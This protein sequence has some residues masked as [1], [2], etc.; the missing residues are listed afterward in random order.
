MPHK[1]FL[2][3]YLMLVSL[4]SCGQQEFAGS[5]GQAMAGGKK[6]G[7]RK[8][9]GD[10]T[11]NLGK[12]Q[13]SFQLEANRGEVDVLWLIDTS[14]SMRDDTEIVRRNFDRF[15]TNIAEKSH[16]RLT[17]VANTTAISLTAQATAA[18]H[19]QVNNTV[20]STD[21]LVIAQRLLNNGTIALRSGAKLV[22]VVVTDDNVTSVTDLNFISGL[23]ATIQAIKPTL[24]AFRGDR[25]QP[26]CNIARK[27]VAYDNLARATGGDVFDICAPDW[28]PNFNKLAESVA[29]IAGTSFKIDDPALD[30]VT[31]VTLDGV[32][33]DPA[34]F[35]VVGSTVQLV[36]KVVKP[37]S[38]EVG[39]RYKT[40]STSA[41]AV[42][43]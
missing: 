33:L 17:L 8:K 19:R 4:V 15:L 28:T 25:D 20:N 39:V 31:Q 36:S 7:G 30:V 10:E 6:G 12:G 23:N 1:T 9:G 24:F 22:M 3:V 2:L 14:G 27:G 16:A 42:K 26:P 21:A 37:T 38:K 35:R 13:K 29:M 32:V 40:K 11:T 18:G 5:S 34:D 43:P 41:N